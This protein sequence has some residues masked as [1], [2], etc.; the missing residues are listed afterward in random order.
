MAR[1]R[2]RQERA[3]SVPAAHVERELALL[4]WYATHS[5]AQGVVERP[6]AKVAARFGVSVESIKRDTLRLEG[7]GALVIEGRYDDPDNRPKR[8]AEE[9]KAAGPSDRTPVPA[10]R[11]QDDLQ[12]V[13]WEP[14][15]GAWLRGQY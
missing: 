8:T 2:P 7:A 14:T 9:W 5:V 12:P 3:R 10:I 1:A 13:I 4:D 15:V 6:V 11:L